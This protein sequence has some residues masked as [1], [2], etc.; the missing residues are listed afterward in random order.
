MRP[1]GRILTYMSFKVQ[2]WSYFVR[3]TCSLDATLLLDARR[4]KCGAREARARPFRFPDYVP[5]PR[6]RLAGWL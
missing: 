4:E 1:C 3:T 6:T 2:Y 5:A